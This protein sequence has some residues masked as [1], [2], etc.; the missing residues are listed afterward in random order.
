MAAHFC[1]D[2]PTKVRETDM[3]VR[4]SELM[5]RRSMLTGVG[6]A[7]AGVAMGATAAGARESSG[8][9]E[10]ARHSE[11][12]WLD[13]LPGNHRVFVDSASGPGGATALLYANNILN[14]HTSAYS[15]KESDYA[16]IVCFRHH[17]T[18]FG[19][20]DEVWEK[21]GEGFNNIQNFPDPKTG[22]APVFNPMNA[23]E[24]RDFP[25]K[26]NTIDSLGSR[27]IEIA[28]CDNATHV[29]SRAMAGATGG[30]ADAIYKELVASLVPNSR[31]VSAGVIAATRAQEYGYSLLSTG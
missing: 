13:A 7:A 9:F 21:Y 27:G 5:A 1:R 15:G 11:D 30:S 8:G 12:A 23:A 18:P 14:A 22:K 26:G 2:T 6:V 20:G 10:P 19:F 16:M 29:I 24:R 31:L 17:S 4:K 3:T 25:N 28:V